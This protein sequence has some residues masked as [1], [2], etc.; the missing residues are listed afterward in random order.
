M[1]SRHGAVRALA[2][3]AALAGIA[4]S[5]QAALG[6]AAHT[7]PPA[8]V[9]RAAA[10][11]TVKRGDTLSAIAD[12]LHIDV[13]ALAA[14]NGIRN[15]HRIHEGQVLKV[16]PPPLPPSMAN[17]PDRL[18]NSPDRLALMGQ[19]DVAAR[20]F[21]VPPDLLKAVAWM[22]SGWQQDKVSS[23][24]AVGVGQ[25]MPATVD[26]MNQLLSAKLDPKRA[27]HNIRL[28]ARY[29]SW[30]LTQTNGDV[31]TA[32][33]AYYQGLTSL[34]KLGPYADTR[35]YVASVVALRSRFA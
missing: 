19:F 13:P 12:R 28:S 3:V 16:P 6:K 29:L 2:V 34:R 35:F 5:G 23:T 32:V 26:F 9:L 24:K 27:D 10:S 18:R 21:R 7:K 4:G 25:L 30:L 11:Y 20:D 1:L 31:P 17:L 33:G 15:V 8:P 22:E 14:A